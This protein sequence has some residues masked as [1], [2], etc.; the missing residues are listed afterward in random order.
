VHA[1]GLGWPD[2]HA[3]WNV[4]FSTRGMFALAPILLCGL[5]GIVLMIRSRFRAE[6]VVCACA[7][8]LQ[9]LL[10]SSY[11]THSASAAFGGLQ[12]TSR[13]LIPAVPFLGVAAVMALRR[14]PVVV[15]SLFVVGA[16]IAAVVTMTHPSSGYDGLWVERLRARTFSPLGWVGVPDWRA[17]L[18]FVLFVGIALAA[19]C[20]TLPRIHVTARA[21][22]VAAAVLA[23]W[24]AFA[25]V[26]RTPWPTL[27][28]K[29]VD[30]LDAF[31]V[32]A[33]VCAGA[34]GLLALYT[35]R[36]RAA[37]P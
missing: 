25:L 1:N 19:T 21:L 13:Y 37:T 7:V 4:L 29:M 3:A 18:P 34:L 23:A 10:D 9:V 15:G 32:F 2:A 16:A 33:L 5:V 24:A 20:W 31:A 27:G 22:A 6:G 36:A 26:D 30:G 17:A 11:F 35:R 8:G 28:L 14:W 12:L